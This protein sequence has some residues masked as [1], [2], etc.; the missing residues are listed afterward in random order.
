MVSETKKLATRV[1]KAEIRKLRSW[2]S[3]SSLYGKYMG[4]QWKQ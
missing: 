1:P 3:V 4:K 2:H